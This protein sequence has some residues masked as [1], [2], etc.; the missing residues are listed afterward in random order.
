MKI[1]HTE[2]RLDKF[3]LYILGIKIT[4]KKRNAK[5][6]NKIKFHT[7]QQMANIIKRNLYK[8]P[9]DID[10]IV[11]VPRSGIIPAYI[12]AL[13]LNKK[14]CSMNE[15]INNL[16]PLNGDRI[17]EDVEIKKV[18][19]VDDS[20]STGSALNKNKKLI[21]DLKLDKKYNIEYCCVFA[22][23]DSKTMIDYYFKKLFQKFLSRK[24]T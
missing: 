20:I 11:G 1:F 19:I 21:Q 18:L 24:K 6:K 5:L 12:I 16:S 17:L 4:I 14:V 9:N 15:F 8:L 13:F 7:F 23:S 2:N 10:L 3:I 22:T